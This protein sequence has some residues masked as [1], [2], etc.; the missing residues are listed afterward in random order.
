MG[1]SLGLNVIAEGIETEAQAEYLKQLWCD[2]AQGFLYSRPLL[3]ADCA[4][5]LRN[6][7]QQT[8][9]PVLEQA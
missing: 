9:L 8:P 6:Q 7:A 3:P 2:D 1:H 4:A 5:F